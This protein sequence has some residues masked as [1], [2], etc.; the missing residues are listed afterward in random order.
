MNY[1]ELEDFKST[2]EWMQNNHPSRLSSKEITES[3]V[4]AANEKLENEGRR[5]YSQWKCGNQ[6]EGSWTIIGE[7]W[8]PLEGKPGDTHTGLLVCIESLTK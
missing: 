5:L 1:F 6:K 4:R 3:F 8:H 2:M 7:Q